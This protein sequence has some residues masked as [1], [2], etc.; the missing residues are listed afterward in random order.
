M[1]AF[2][3]DDLWVRKSLA[4]AESGEG[5]A[6]AEPP[7]RQRRTM[8]MTVVPQNEREAAKPVPTT[9]DKLKVRKGPRDGKTREK[10]RIRPESRT[11]NAKSKGP[12]PTPRRHQLE[13]G[14]SKQ[15]S[16]P[17]R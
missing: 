10:S 16:K 3:G 2:F 15:P 4:Q 11:T 5:D 8:S 6:K 13:G 9:R 1:W 17:K 7:V 14:N 12:S